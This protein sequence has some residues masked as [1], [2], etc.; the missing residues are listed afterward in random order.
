MEA[1]SLPFDDFNLVIDPFQPPCM[2]RIVTVIKDPILVTPQSLSKLFHRRMIHTLCQHTPFLNGL[3]GPCPGSVRPDVFEFVFEDQHR[4]DDCVQLEQLFQVLPIFRLTDIPPVFQQKIFAALEDFFVGLGGFPVFAVTHFIDNPVELRHHMEEVENDLDM[5]DL[6]PHGQDIGIPH[7]HHHRFQLLSLL[8]THT[9][10]ESPQGS[11]FA[12]LAHPN[13]TPCLV[14]QDH[15]H[16][17]VA[18]ADGDFVDGQDA[19]PLIIGLPMLSLQELLID[20]LDCFPVQSQMAGDFLDGHDFAEFE[21]ITRQPLGHPQ[22][23]IEQIELF[24]GNLL[25]VGTDDLPVLTVYPEACRTKVQVSD[26]PPLLAVD[27]SGPAPADMADRTESPVGDC[28]QISPLTVGGYPLSDNPDSWKGEIVCYTQRG[29]HRPPLDVDLEM[30]YL[31]YPLEI[32]DVHFLFQAFYFGL[33]F[34]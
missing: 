13:N 29:H 31:Y 5:R 26:P 30:T 3:L 21:N 7:V 33:F 14:V 11:G 27:S 19:K 25:T 23:R 1:I 18:F 10:E 34:N 24:D 17:A 6:G 12:V 9:R 32:P 2:N 22:V 4:I 20:G 8:G 15:R 16:V 28:L